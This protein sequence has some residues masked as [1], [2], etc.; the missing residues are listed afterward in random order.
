MV[1]TAELPGGEPKQITEMVQRKLLGTLLRILTA[2][3]LL[4]NIH[5]LPQ[6]KARQTVTK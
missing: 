3:Q 5:H 6:V 4:S 2:M 1:I